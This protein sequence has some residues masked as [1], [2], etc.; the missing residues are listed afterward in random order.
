MLEGAAETQYCVHSMLALARLYTDLA[1][2]LGVDYFLTIATD[3]CQQLR[4]PSLLW[5]ARLERARVQL[6]ARQLDACKASLTTL[7]RPR[8]FFPQRHRSPQSPART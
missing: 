5:R 2:L 7:V 1:V 8:M 4:M 3:W 6:A